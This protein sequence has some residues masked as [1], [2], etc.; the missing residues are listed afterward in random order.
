MSVAARSRYAVQLSGHDHH[1][2]RAERAR[3]DP[4]LEA[5]SSC[6]DALAFGEC[7][8]ERPAVG[9]A[10]RDSFIA[11]MNGERPRGLISDSVRQGTEPADHHARVASVDRDTLW[12]GGKACSLPKKSTGC[13]REAG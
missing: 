10:K 2:A 7:A 12:F 4:S 1:F 11:E 5:L 9:D 13:R 3:E 6:D 8:Y